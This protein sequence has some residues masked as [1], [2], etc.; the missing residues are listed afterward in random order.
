[1]SS[2]ISINEISRKGPARLLSII[3][4]IL[5]ILLVCVFIYDLFPK[6]AVYP[7]GVEP[8]EIAFGIAGALSLVTP[9]ALYLV[10]KSPIW[11][12]HRVLWLFF[13]AVGAIPCMLFWLAIVG[14]VFEWGFLF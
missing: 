3:S 14:Y 6:E 13:I 8:I 7:D 2:G 1:M 11:P 4:A 10:L 9:C 12:G 5:G